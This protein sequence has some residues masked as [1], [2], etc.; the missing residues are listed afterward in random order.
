MTRVGVPRLLPM[1]AGWALFNLDRSYSYDPSSRV[2][3]TKPSLWASL[4]IGEFNDSPPTTGCTSV[5]RRTGILPI[6]PACL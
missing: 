5:A 6:S 2:I 3:M 4:A 1:P